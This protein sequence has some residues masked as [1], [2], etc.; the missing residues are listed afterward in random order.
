MC[1][2]GRLESLDLKLNVVVNQSHEAA[3]GLVRSDSINQYTL[4]T[5]WGTVDK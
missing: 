5:F 1:H 4:P 3:I 2:L